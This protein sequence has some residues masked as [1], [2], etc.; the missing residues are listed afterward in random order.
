M[1]VLN[2]INDDLVVD[3]MVYKQKMTND[4]QTKMQNASILAYVNQGLC[5]ENEE[6]EA[7][8]KKTQ[9]LELELRKENTKLKELLKEIRQQI[10]EQV[11]GSL[12]LQLFRGTFDNK[13][14]AKIDEVLK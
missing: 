7:R 3:D 11:F 12:E 2:K 6:P 10:T 13:L 5:I 14:L 8:L 9:E 4:L 1:T